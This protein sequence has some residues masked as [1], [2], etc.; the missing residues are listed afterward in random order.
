MTPV[1]PVVPVSVL[2]V[3]PEVL[4]EVAEPLLRDSSPRET[5]PDE[6]PVRESKVAPA[7]P[8]DLVGIVGGSIGRVAAQQTVLLTILVFCGVAAVNTTHESLLKG[9][10]VALPFGVSMPL[11]AF[12][13]AAPVLIVALHANLLIQ[14]RTLQE[15]VSRF[16]REVVL[17]PED[18]ALL[19]PTLISLGI[20]RSFQGSRTLSVLLG[21]CAFL[22]PLLT[23]VLLQTQFL[24][25]HHGGMTAWHRVLVALNTLMVLAS[26]A[27]W[28]IYRSPRVD[29]EA[30]SAQ[31]A[32]VTAPHVLVRTLFVG[33]VLFAGIY[34]FGIAVLPGTSPDGFRGR[35][36]GTGLKHWVLA[37][38]PQNLILKEANL[39]ER[40]VPAEALATLATNR[41]ATLRIPSKIGAE[42]PLAPP[43]AAVLYAKGLDLRNRDLRGAT[44]EGSTLIRADFRGALLD[45]ANF[46]KCVLTGASFANSRITAAKF[47][48]SRLEQADFGRATVSKSD[49]QG[50]VLGGFL[51]T[52]DTE[53]VGVNFTGADLRN[54]VLTGR[55]SRCVFTGIQS[56]PTKFLGNFEK[57]KFDGPTP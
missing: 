10:P 37:Y 7:L 53:F 34:S 45:R 30:R 33:L 8:K 23:L 28:G 55:Y 3:E 2:E 19:P 52:P 42:P 4:N 36:L 20:R 47:R 35:V 49:F 14:I 46:E 27:F 21:A 39:L 1:E 31:R 9:T 17:T 41:G 15:Q 6:P 40:E 48:F 51:D 38:C 29:K 18:G 56:Q 16:E 43:A 44:F 57:S 22:L 32:L 24:P 12:Y 11:M 26:S 50:A 54:A 5:I 13:V 25:Y